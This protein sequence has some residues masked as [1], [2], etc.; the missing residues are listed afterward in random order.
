MEVS[1]PDSI[2]K[3]RENMAGQNRLHHNGVLAKGDAGYNSGH[4]WH[5]LP[6]T[7]RMVEI[8]A[9]VCDG[10]PSYV[11]KDIDHWV[12]A[13]KTYC[14]WPGRVVQELGPTR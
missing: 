4:L 11:D 12:T 13:V 9:E 2:R 3:A 5:L 14:P 7:V 10:L 1:D 8:S 6:A